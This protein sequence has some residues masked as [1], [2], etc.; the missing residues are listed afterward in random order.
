MNVGFGLG[1]I[2][3]QTDPILENQGSRFHFFAGFWRLHRNGRRLM[4]IS[5]GVSI[6]WVWGTVL[7]VH[8]RIQQR[9]LEVAFLWLVF[10]D[11]VLF[12]FFNHASWLGKNISFFTSLLRTL[13][14]SFLSH[15]MIFTL[16]KE[17][18]TKW[19]LLLFKVIKEGNTCICTYLFILSPYSVF[20]GEAM[21]P[22]ELFFWALKVYLMSLRHQSSRAEMEREQP[23][24][25]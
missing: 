9:A 8:L 25:I 16:R 24:C 17:W 15:R 12:C 21:K 3:T 13:P 6:P 2:L 5:A 7:W 19:Q 4:Q 11:F 1:S 10:F 20:Y 22:I 18:G 23:N 14:C